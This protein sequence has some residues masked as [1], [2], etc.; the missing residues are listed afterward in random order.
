MKQLNFTQLTR[1]KTL[2]LQAMRS[3]HANGKILRFYVISDDTDVL[4][5]LCYQMSGLSFGDAIIS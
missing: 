4:T 3:G 1:R 5:L 2:D